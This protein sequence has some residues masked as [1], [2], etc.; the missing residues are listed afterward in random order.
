MAVVVTHKDEGVGPPRNSRRRVTLGAGDTSPWYQVAEYCV[1]SCIP[2]GG[3]TMSAE[4]TFSP[5][6]M[7]LAD[8]SNGTSTVAAHVWTPGTVAAAANQYLLKATA[9]RFI[10]TAAAGV[11]EIAS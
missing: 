6:S 4:C 5:L 2:G 7:V 8:N 3:G 1:V 9:V 10:A 11:G